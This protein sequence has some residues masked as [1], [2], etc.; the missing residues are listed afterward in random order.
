MKGGARLPRLFCADSKPTLIA[1][2]NLYCHL[3]PDHNRLGWKQTSKQTAA[4]QTSGE[5]AGWQVVRQRG[6]VWEGRGGRR[7]GHPRARLPRSPPPASR[8]WD[9]FPPI[10]RPLFCRCCTVSLSIT[11]GN[12][13]GLE[14]FPLP[15]VFPGCVLIDGF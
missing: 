12:E 15:T 10:P 14:W 9:T 1:P 7:P 6:P 11:D 4:E 8:C 2:K 13:I 5:A 3:N